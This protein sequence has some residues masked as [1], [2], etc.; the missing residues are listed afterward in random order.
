MVRINVPAHKVVV[1][2]LAATG[3]VIFVGPT[4]A[5]RGMINSNSKLVAGSKQT[6]NY[7]VVGDVDAFGGR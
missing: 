3:G 1:G 5:D 6:G 4:N 2:A 7:P